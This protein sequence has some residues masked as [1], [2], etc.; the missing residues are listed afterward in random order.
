MKENEKRKEGDSN[1]LVSLDILKKH[2]LEHHHLSAVQI[3]EFVQ[4]EIAIPVSCFN[5]KLS[6][7][8]SVVKFLKEE[9]DFNYHKIGLMLERD[10]RNI[11]TT[12]ANSQK[13]MKAK[14]DVSSSIRIPISE[15]KNEAGLFAAVKYL[16]ENLDVTYHKIGVL[17][18]RDERTIWITYNKKS[19]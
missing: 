11:W 2:L 16:K 17:L 19:K 9:Q 15:F 12:Y 6:I 5:E 7:L 4:S 13:K 14:L 18:S 10:E 8:E 3:N 1:S